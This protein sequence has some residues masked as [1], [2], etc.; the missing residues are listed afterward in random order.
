MYQIKFELLQSWR[1]S[2]RIFSISMTTLRF[3]S[4]SKMFA[5]KTKIMSRRQVLNY[6]WLLLITHFT[7]DYCYYL[8]HH[9]VISD[10]YFWNN[11]LLNN[12]LV[13]IETAESVQVELD[14]RHHVSSSHNR[15]RETSEGSWWVSNAGASRPGS[16]LSNIGF[17]TYLKLYL[18]PFPRYRLALRRQKSPRPIWAPDRGYP[19]QISRWNLSRYTLRLLYF[20]MWKPRD[21]NFSLLVT[22]HSQHKH[23]TD[24]Q[25]DRRHTMT[26]SEHCNA[27]CNVRLKTKN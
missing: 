12:V 16:R 1:I 22:I 17:E 2:Y 18:A 3:F 25:T 10:V 27:N 20:H 24:R 4:H 23:V 6:C 11:N 26:L 14:S 5:L 19:L 7:I 15:E 21:H 9:D 8:W 13:I